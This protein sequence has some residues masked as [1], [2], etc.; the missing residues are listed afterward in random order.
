MTLT[1]FK[2]IK[3]DYLALAVFAALIVIFYGN[4]LFN[5]F[6]LDDRAV[7]VENIYIQSLRYLPKVITGCLWE[8]AIG[9]CKGQTLHYRPIH[10]LSYLLTYQISSGAWFFHLIN[11]IYFFIAVYLVFILIKTITHNFTLSFFTALLFLVHPIN[12][13]VINW[14]AAVSE[15]TFTIL[16]SLAVIYY[17]KY[18]D[19]GLTKHLILVYLFYFLAM[20][21]KEVAV[22]LPL[23]LIS[24]DLLL[25]ETSIKKLFSG[26]R[27]KLNK[28]LAF[29]GPLFVYFFM[30]M[31]VIGTFGGFGQGEKYYVQFNFLERIYTFFTLFAQYLQKLF[32]PYPLLFFYDFKVRADLADSRF[33][34]SLAVFLAFFVILYLSIKK[35]RNLLSLSL[36][37]F[38][39]FILSP[40]IF[41]D[42]VGENIFAER[43]LFIS[44]IGFALVIASLLDYLWQKNKITQAVASIIIIFIVLISWSVIY[45]RNRIWKDNI[46]LFQATLAQNPN[47]YPIR[48]HLATDLIEQG[49][50]ERAKIEFEEIVHQK[51]DWKY[52]TKVYNHLG[53][54]YRGKG[55]LDKAEEYYKKAVETADILG[56]YKAYNNLGDFYVERNENLRALTYFCKALQVN[57][58]APEPKNNFGRI[59]SMIEEVTTED[60][61]F[62]YMD[63]T[64]GG[65]FEKSEEKKIQYRNRVCLADSCFYMFIP[66]IEKEETMLPFLIMAEAF[67]SEIIKIKNS[68][69]SQES[70]V[71]V[72][73]IDENYNDNVITFMFP[74]CEGVYYE[75]T[76]SP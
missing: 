35:N 47:A 69:F 49:D 76:A 36:I 23:V 41:F 25:Y 17:I 8:H 4:T 13:E 15:L 31:A 51:P 65:A 2:N 75:V 68:F 67:P 74:T 29:I 71:I 66:G 10:S 54:Y 28:Y 73:S 38:F 56:D 9:G 3:K 72:V 39:I 40:I 20:L 61:M 22:L 59:A 70:R 34:I 46:T 43:Y 57:P 52:I 30:R 48:N 6:V 45:P 62:L 64:Q 44:S 50:L 26:G 11:L 1:F 14:V 53:D 55:E 63:F 42:V 37:W 21:S 18:H 60:F 32:L 33:L 19:T 5:G 7:V 16:V 12:N 24:I 27:E 58:E